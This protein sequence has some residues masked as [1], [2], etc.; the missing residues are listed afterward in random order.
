MHDYYG[1]II[2]FGLGVWQVLHGDYLWLVV[3]IISTGIFVDLW[4]HNFKHL[5]KPHF[6]NE[7]A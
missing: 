4:A 1:L 2:M 7:K 3:V 5:P 6:S